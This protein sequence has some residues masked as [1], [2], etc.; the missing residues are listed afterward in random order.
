MTLDL[1]YLV[2]GALVMALVT[3]LPRMLPLVLL[4]KKIESRW[5]QSF[6]YYIPYAVLA[7]MTLPDLLFSTGQLT[8]AL[9][10]GGLAIVLA[11]RGG[12]LLTVAL[13]SAGAVWLAELFLR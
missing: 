2:G 13:C 1:T 12:S 8:S 11:W 5:L 3:Y 9:L 4:R 7:A 6:L 10:G